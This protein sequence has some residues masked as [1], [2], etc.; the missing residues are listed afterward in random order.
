MRADLGF[1]QQLVLQRN[2]LHDVLARLDHPAAR[3]HPDVLHDAVYRRGQH[4]ARHLVLAGR[5]R[6]LHLGQFGFHAGQVVGGIHTVLADP[7]LHGGLQVVVLPLQ[8]QQLGL[9]HQALGHHRLGD[10]D[11]AADQRLAGLGRGDGLLQRIPAGVVGVGLVVDHLGIGQH[12]FRELQRRTPGFGA[13]T[14]RRCL[15]ADHLAQTFLVGR[16]CLGLVNAQQRLA[17]LHR[18]AFA[19]QH[20]GQNAAFQRLD[21][22]L[23]AG[24]D[25]ACI[26][27][28]DLFQLAVVGP[29]G[30]RHQQRHHQHQQQE[31]A[32]LAI[33][34]HRLLHVAHEVEVAATARIRGV[35]EGV[36]RLYGIRSSYCHGPLGR[37]CRAGCPRGAGCIRGAG[38]NRL[39]LAGFGR[40]GHHGAPRVGFLFRHDELPGSC[41]PSVPA[42]PL[43]SAHR[44]PAR[45]HP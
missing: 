19:H 3:V 11:L 6:F 42:A 28:G 44:P 32:L 24:G 17:F 33:V 12:V 30:G 43:P 36:A 8:A 34:D 31:A 7:L 29:D 1:H 9:G 18:G 25:D 23:A 27:L 4:R 13:Q 21:H 39:R 15:Q 16:T 38:R 20:L 22:L 10:V 2:D 35:G 26:P 37:R 45:L 40:G 14:R 5:Q 41:L